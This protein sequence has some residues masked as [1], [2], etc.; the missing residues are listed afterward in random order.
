MTRRLGCEDDITEAAILAK[1]AEVARIITT[2]QE[3]YR[4]LS[5][6]DDNDKS[7]SRQ[8]FA[9]PFVGPPQYSLFG[10]SPDGFLCL[11]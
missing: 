2:W 7:Q 5:A 6:R 9:R 11:F 4:K 8:A 3:S 10:A 1:A